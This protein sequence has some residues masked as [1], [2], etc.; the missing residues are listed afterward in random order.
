M[1]PATKKVDRPPAPGARLEVRGEEWVLRR[2]DR[3]FDGHY[4]LSVTGLSPLVRD[5]DWKFLTELDA[6]TEVDP[7][8]VILKH[9]ESAGYAAAKLHIE[10]LLRTTPPTDEFL[11]LGHRGAMDDVPYQ[12]L[13]ALLALEQPRP[14]ILIADGTGLG[15]TLE[16]GI[17][18]AELMRR[19][20][21]RRIL[22]VTLKSMLTQFQKELWSRFAIPLVRLDSLGIQRVRDKI[23][24][25][26]NPFN[27]FDKSIISIDT[28]K[29]ASDYR[30][31]IEQAY[32][33]IIVIDEAQ[34][35]ANRGTRSLRNQL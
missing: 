30:V 24:V 2:A 7:K 13:P 14:R 31:F 19:G 15:K 29:S 8:Q 5:Q 11:Y 1:S 26:H 3:T 9:D 12:R 28:L 23:P 18:I 34:N 17:L 16:A 33:D 10:C 22:V 20:R 27:H 4:V 32:W 21:G 35:V 25:G 6:F